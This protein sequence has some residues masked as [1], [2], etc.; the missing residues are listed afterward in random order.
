LFDYLNDRAS[1]TQDVLLNKHFNI[2]K[3]KGKDAVYPYRWNYVEDKEY[4]CNETRATMLAGFKKAGIPAERLDYKMTEA[5]WHILYSVSDKQELNK[6]LAKFANK[7]HLQRPNLMTM[8]MEHIR[9]K[10]SRSCCR[11]C[12]EVNIGATMP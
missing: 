5:L 6:A 9:Q 10:L 3:P 7:N 8:I 4:P 1:I 12:V 2:K 11:L